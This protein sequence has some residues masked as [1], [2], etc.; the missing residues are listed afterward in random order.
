MEFSVVVIVF[1]SFPFAANYLFAVFRLLGAEK[2]KETARMKSA[3]GG[4]HGEQ[5]ARLR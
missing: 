5:R 3:G 1:F 2:W 4:I